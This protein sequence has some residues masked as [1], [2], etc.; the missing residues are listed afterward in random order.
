MV[1]KS[2][3]EKLPVASKDVWRIYSAIQIAILVIVYIAA[4]YF[5]RNFEI[6]MYVLVLIAILLLIYSVIIYWVVPNIRWVILSYEV[7]E[8]EIE[9]QTG[10]F[11]IKRSIIPIIRVQHVD[12]N[13]GP[14]IKRKNLASIDITTAA[15]T[16]TI[17]LLTEQE[18]DRLRLKISELARVAK[19]DV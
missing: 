18:S 7:R 5:T 8:H 9:I 15:T 17:P 11:I 10:L 14:I 4:V 19:E 1:N 2:L 6:P 16:H 12:V 3:Q 13:S